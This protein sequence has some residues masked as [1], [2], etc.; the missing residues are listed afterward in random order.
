M[1]GELRRVPGEYSASPPEICRRLIDGDPRR[2]R[3]LLRVL[4]CTTRIPQQQSWERTRRPLSVHAANARAAD[5]SQ[6]EQRPGRQGPSPWPLA[7]SLGGKAD[8]FRVLADGS[9]E[10]ARSPFR[11]GGCTDTIMRP[12]TTTLRK[13]SRPAASRREIREKIERAATSSPAL[14][15]SCDGHFARRAWRGVHLVPFCLSPSSPAGLVSFVPSS[16]WGPGVALRVGPDQE[17]KRYPAT[18]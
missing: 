12:R 6:Q 5:G 16:A 18:H 11:R 1:T 15:K 4:L 14:P 9:K 8:T 7:L 3:L 13:R 2:P 17:K 10:G